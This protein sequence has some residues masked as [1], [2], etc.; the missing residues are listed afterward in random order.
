[1]VDQQDSKLPSVFPRRYYL[2]L[3]DDDWIADTLSDDEIDVP[4]GLDIDPNSGESPSGEPP[5]WAGDAKMDR[6]NDLGLDLWA[7]E[8][9]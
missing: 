3:V 9:P 1:C 8:A 2:D 4:P 7:R 5:A 6:W